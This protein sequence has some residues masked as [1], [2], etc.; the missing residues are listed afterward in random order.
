MQATKS[1]A[2]LAWPTS[3]IVNGFVGA[4]GNTPLV[5]R[6][7]YRPLLASL[8]RHELQIRLEKWYEKT[9]CNIVAKAE[10]QNPGGSVKDRAALGVV[11]NAERL[12]LYVRPAILRWHA[13]H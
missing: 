13:R 1:L 9:G 3:R 4:L 12:G 8:T 2:S 5:S 7:L 11:E 10:F 6:T